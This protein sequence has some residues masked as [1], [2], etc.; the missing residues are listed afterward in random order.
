MDEDIK[1]T[2]PGKLCGKGFACRRLTV[3][4]CRLKALLIGS[5]ARPYM[6]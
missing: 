1:A 4:C 6:A 2:L 5:R 3:G